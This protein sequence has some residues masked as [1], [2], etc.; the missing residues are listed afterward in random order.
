MVIIGAVLDVVEIFNAVAG[1]LRISSPALALQAG[2]PELFTH[3]KYS[4]DRLVA[5]S[6]NSLFNRNVTSCKAN[7]FSLEEEGE[8]LFKSFPVPEPRV[9]RSYL[10]EARTTV[11]RHAVQTDLAGGRVGE[12]LI[13]NCTSPE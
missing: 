3:A 10:G 9:E 1:V 12:C 13:E 5:N 6:K 11:N 8:K 4:P 2:S 7:V